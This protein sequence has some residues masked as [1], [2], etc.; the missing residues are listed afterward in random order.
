MQWETH[1]VYWSFYLPCGKEVH[2]E[3][4]ANPNS[5][6]FLSIV[7]SEKCPFHVSQWYFPAFGSLFLSGNRI[8]TQWNE[9]FFNPWLKR[10]L[11]LVHYDKNSL[12]QHAEIW[13]KVTKVAEGDM[14]PRSC[15]YI[16]LRN[17]N[18]HKFLYLFVFRFHQDTART[19]SPQS[20]D[21]NCS[22]AYFSSDSSRFL[23]GL[24]SPPVTLSLSFLTGVNIFLCSVLAK[25]SNIFMRLPEKSG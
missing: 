9:I 17:V 15:K 24:N 18:F 14:T 7:L 13:L 22:W 1:K 6:P 19:I 16:M 11:F 21:F 5:S 4:G 23:S 20:S 25:R 8:G 3:G 10:W 2:N 12:S